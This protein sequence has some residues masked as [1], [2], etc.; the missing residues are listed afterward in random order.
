MQTVT[1][2]TPSQTYSLYI[3]T[4]HP[5]GTM[6]L[7][8]LKNLFHGTYFVVSDSNVAPL[9]M[10]NIQ[11]TLH[12]HLD[13]QCLGHFILPFGEKNKNFIQL[14]DL[15]NCLLDCHVHR[16][17]TLIALGG[18][19]VGDIT[20]FAASIFH[21]GIPYIQYPTTLVS[22]VDSSVGGKT[23]INHRGKNI[24][25][26]FYHPRAV[27][28]DPN[29]LKTLPV[30]HLLSGFSEIAK[31]ALILDPSFWETL[32]LH[33]PCEFAKESPQTIE[34]ILEKACRLKAKI[35]THDDKETSFRALLNLG[36]TFGHALETFY[37]YE[38]HLYH[39]EAVAIG[40]VMAFALSE[41]LS[42]CPTG[43]HK[44]V[45]TQFQKWG[46]KTSLAHLVNRPTRSEMIALMKTDKKNNLDHFTFILNKK[47]GESMLV[48]SVPV[49]ALEKL[50]RNLHFEE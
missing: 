32:T 35:V 28:I 45:Q 27:I 12:A 43:L 20:G 34:T 42:Y 16:S 2:E 31:I 5:A 36:H 9:Y 48:S 47:I 21:R 19:V 14:Q 38:E 22:Q 18:G 11:H 37:E 44:T 1:L 41:Q 23:G 6:N 26:S 7:E 29:F 49:H 25:G 39:G 8:P 24:I 30:R 15:L 3:Q 40:I 50:L 46:F 10:E 17:T 13:Q 4:C 33:N